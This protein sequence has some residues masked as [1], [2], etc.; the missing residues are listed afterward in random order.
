MT[1][2]ID[3]NDESQNEGQSLFIGILKFIKRSS[4]LTHCFGGFKVIRICL[5]KDRD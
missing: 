3:E 2:F 1:D 4:I 5:S